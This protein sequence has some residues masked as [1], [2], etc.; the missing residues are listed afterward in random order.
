MPGPTLPGTKA[1]G[2][3]GEPG[4]PWLEAARCAQVLRACTPQPPVPWAPPQRA[5]GPPPPC[6]A[7]HL[8]GR[9]RCPG[10]S[11]LCAVGCCGGGSGNLLRAF[12]KE[13]SSP[14]W[15]QTCL[16]AL[17]VSPGPC[18]RA[19]RTL[20][21]HRV[22]CPKCSFF[23]S[24]RAHPL[25][26]TRSVWAYQVCFHSD[27]GWTLLATAPLICWPPPGPWA[28]PEGPYG[29]QHQAVYC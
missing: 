10:L 21:L 4:Q 7:G 6:A 12:L 2:G 11:A 28:V 9:A 16:R 29:G 5:P 18:M 13:V 1:A 15:P 14:S 27:W 22:L 3:W 24:P 20:G 17:L 25:P 8:S 26:L 23:L 19:P